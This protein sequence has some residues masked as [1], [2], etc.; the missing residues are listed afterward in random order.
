MEDINEIITN[1]VTKANFKNKDAFKA[2]VSKCLHFSNDSSKSTYAV[3]E[4]MVF[5]VDTFFKEFSPFKNEFGR[6][7]IYEAGVEAF[8]CIFDELGIDLSKEEC[9]LLYHLRDVGKFRVKESVFLEEVKALWKKYPDYE[10]NPQ[11]FSY[12][13]KELMRAKLIDYRRGNLYLKNSIIIR[14]RTNT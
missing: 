2:F 5:K 13:L 7:K 4:N 8:S 14:Y 11:D 10:L 6:D 9:F 12:G 1:I 3:F